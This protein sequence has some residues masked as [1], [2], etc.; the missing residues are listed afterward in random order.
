MLA[1]FKFDHLSSSVFDYVKS[2]CVKH[3]FHSPH[4]NL[5]CKDQSWMFA[6]YLDFT[7]NKIPLIEDHHFRKPLLN[8]PS[9]LAQS[10]WLTEFAFLGCLYFD[11]LKTS[12]LHQLGATNLGSWTESPQWLQFE[13]DALD[14]ISFVKKDFLASER[15][16]EGRSIGSWDCFFERNL[17]QHSWYTQNRP[18]RARFG[19]SNFLQSRYSWLG[20]ALS[21]LAL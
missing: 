19:H 10:A 12:I 14:L 6:Y 21:E 3:S 13:L 16:K 2:L 5:E 18:Y 7:L 1:I 9:R 15:S 4:L 17:W 20:G 11:E 8:N